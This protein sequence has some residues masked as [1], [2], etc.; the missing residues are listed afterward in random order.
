M[1]QKTFWNKNTTEVLTFFSSLLYGISDSV[2]DI[3]ECFSSESTL[4]GNNEH[5]WV[6][7]ESAL[8]SQMRWV[9]T[10]QTDEIPIFNG[11]GTIGEHVSNELRVDFGSCVETN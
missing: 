9:L 8:K 7:L 4:F 10:H 11:G 3:W 6:S 5:I 2:Y 1:L